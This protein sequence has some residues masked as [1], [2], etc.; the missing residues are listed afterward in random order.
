[1][2]VR[3]VALKRQ[4]SQTSHAASISAWWA[5]FERFSIVAALRVSRQGPASNSAARRKIATRSSHGV[6]LQ[7]CQASPAALTAASTSPGP[8]WWTSAR[9]WCRSCGMTASRITPVRT[10]LPPMMQGI[11]MRSPRISSTRSFRLPPPPPAAAR[12]R[13]GGGWAGGRFLAR[14]WRDGTL[15]PRVG[16]KAIRYETEGWGV[17]ELWL[18]GDRVVWH[19]LPQD[20]LASDE[21]GRHPLVERLPAYFAG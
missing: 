13:R 14:S 12:R 11:S 10:S 5:V 8:P 4:K 18:D 15:A 16:V 7:S 19:E 3:Y 6:R 1:M 9:A 17:G 21:R 2:R 20:G